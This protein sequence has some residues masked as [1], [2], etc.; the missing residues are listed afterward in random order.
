[1]CRDCTSYPVSSISTLTCSAMKGAIAPDDT[2]LPAETATVVDAGGSGWRT[3]D[4]FRRTVI[5]HSKTRVLA[6]I[7][8]VGKGMVG[9]AAESDTN[10]MDSE[11]TTATIKANRDYIVG[12]KT[13]HFG[14]RGWTAIDRA[15]AAGRLGGSAGHGR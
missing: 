15:V 3:Y 5:T 8:I 13:A 14:G 9:S 7:N 6:L 12:I 2:A 1:M 10:D 4:E 11:R